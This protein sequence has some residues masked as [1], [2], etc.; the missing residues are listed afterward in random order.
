VNDTGAR[1]DN[2][3]LAKQGAG[4]V[5]RV[6]Q[7]ARARNVRLKLSAREGLTV[8]VPVHF[9]PRRIPAIIE[10]KKAWIE[11]HLRRFRERAAVPASSA[12]LPER[13]ELAALG[14]SWTVEYR[15]A[16]TQLLGVIAA[17]P[18]RLVV[19]GAVDNRVACREALKGWLRLRTREEIVP[20][21]AGLAT[22]IGFTF[23]DALIRG[24]KT[25]WA[26]CSAQ[27]TISLSYKLLF[28]ERECVRFVLV[29]ELCH[30]AVMNH[31]KEFWTLMASVEPECDS[32]RKRM[33][34]SWK[35]VPP[36]V[37]EGA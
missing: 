15:P 33:R 14:E 28:L 34:D 5:Y 37:E 7:S 13:L 3:S 36:W 1:A 24:Q 4:V 2:T 18:G 32:L 35:K 9:D 12:T 16:R 23:R 20:W 17:A 22:R 8:V 29:H 27:G 26:S 11:H 30:R 25:R 19:Y 10:Q 6:R 31:S 21:L